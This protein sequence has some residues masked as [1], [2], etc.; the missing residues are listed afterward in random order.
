MLG[1]ECLTAIQGIGARQCIEV[2]C[3]QVRARGQVGSV[4]ER[5]DSPRF[6][7]APG[8]LLLRAFDVVEAQ[9]Y[10]RLSP[11]GIGFMFG[12]PGADIHINRPHHDYMAA[13]VP[14]LG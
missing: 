13:G 9:A 1:G 10:G 8:G 2:A 4:L 11:M 3:I 6:L 14:Q 12:V 5:L 7:D